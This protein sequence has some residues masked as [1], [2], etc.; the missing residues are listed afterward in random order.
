MPPVI[1]VAFADDT[2]RFQRVFPTPLSRNQVVLL[3]FAF[4][5]F[6]L[7]NYTT[8]TLVCQMKLLY[9]LWE[10]VFHIFFPNLCKTV[11]KSVD[12][13]ENLHIPAKIRLFSRF[14]AKKLWKTFVGKSSFM[15]IFYKPIDFL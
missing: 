9:F 11:E 12:C 3:S 8:K 14:Y 5:D 7:P 10:K 4:F 15:I 2:N 1:R 13:A 6:S